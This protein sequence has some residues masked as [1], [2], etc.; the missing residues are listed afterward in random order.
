MTK[1]TNL[2]FMQVCVEGLSLICDDAF[3]RVLSGNLKTCV[4]ISVTAQE[5]ESKKE[6]CN[7]SRI[8]PENFRKIAY[9][10]P[11]YLTILISVQLRSEHFGVNNVTSDTMFHE[12]SCRPVC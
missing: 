8:I 2:P 3:V 5:N 4:N 9:L 6:H 1:L 12:F 7:I 11:I 10:K